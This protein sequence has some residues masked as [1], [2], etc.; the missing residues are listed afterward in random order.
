MNSENKETGMISRTFLTI[1]SGA[2]VFMFALSPPVMAHQ[3]DAKK[4][5][6]AAT[7]AKTDVA[8][9][10]PADMMRGKGMHLPGRLSMPE[11][12]PVRGM[13]LFVSKGCVACHSVNGVGGHDAPE[14]DAH[15]MTMMMNPFEFAA[16][17]WNSAVTMATLQEEAFGEQIRLTGDELADIVAFV[18]NDEAQH[19]FSERNLTPRARKMM[20]HSHGGGDRQEGHADDG[21]GHGHPNGQGHKKMH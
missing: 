17:L 12:D 7:R 5:P 20:N 16:K 18:H 4:R 14:L 19:T 3:G 13:G 10:G 2:T 8:P 1:L 9:A 11:M 6:D 21:T 15:T